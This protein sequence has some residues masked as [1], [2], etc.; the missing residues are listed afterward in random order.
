MSNIRKD[1]DPH[2]KLT[3]AELLY[4]LEND[5]SDI[6]F[7]SDDE[8]ELDEVCRDQTNDNVL[9]GISTEDR[10]NEDEDLADEQ[11]GPEEIV[12]GENDKDD[13]GQF[14]KEKENFAK[15]HNLT[16]KSK[17]RWIQKDNIEYETRNIHWHAS[18]PSTL[19][20]DL[21]AP[22]KFF[23]KYIPDK[24]LQQM[25][26]MTNLYAT[27]QNTARFPS[28]SLTEIKSFIGIHII[29]GNLQ[30]PRVSMYWHRSM[31]IP[32]VKD[33]M[34]LSRFYKLRQAIHIVDITSREENNQDRL[35]K[36]RCLY[37]S[38]RRRCLK[39]PLET[40]LCV[41]EQ[42]VPFKGQI[43]IKQYV[44]NKPT[45]WGIKIY[46]LAGQSGLIY[47]F[48][49]YQGST[50]PFSPIYVKYGSAAAV[51]MQLSERISESNHGLFFDNYFTTYNLIQYLDS[52]HIYCVGTI[53]ANR[54]ANPR[55][56][57]DKEMK[58]IGRGSSAVS[59]SKDGIVITKW[60]DNKAVLTASN[61]VGIGVADVCRRWD[62]T[63]KEYVQVPR[64]EAIRRYNSNMGG[65]DK[66]DFLL[67]LYRSYVRSKKW[68]VRMITHAIDLALVN[69]WLEYRTQAILLGLP[70]KDILDLLGFRMEVAE[71]LI[72]TRRAPKR[73]R[74][75]EQIENRVI[76]GKKKVEIR[77]TNA[78]RFDKYDH[79]PQYDDKKEASR[80]K[81][82]DCKSR[83]HIY[84][85]KCKVH[86]CILKGRN[87]FSKFHSN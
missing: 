30:F 32:L 4:Y 72:Y 84:C 1:K 39:L 76:R 16:E 64:P 25:A 12:I 81:N 61:F 13:R 24:I 43:N 70:K 26:D 67:S 2:R 82:Q 19:V 37:E 86:L 34:P 40:N 48:L 78:Q 28:T 75:S 21:P 51:V 63:R 47:D 23:T 11:E 31:G 8:L 69:S 42:I 66:L 73:G 83:T 59:I 87:C 68:T 9:D 80:C 14:E 85:Q 20:V 35:W 44:K 17:I 77:P 60:Y 36:V 33:N 52:K 6:E 53:R 3:E 29:M 7:L 71:S 41:D 62:K 65:V 49:I 58:K 57:S 79:L 5:I 55:L 18:Q 15:I 54:F 10:E 22:V 38:V 74:P 50:T 27:Q 56:P 46:V 45:K